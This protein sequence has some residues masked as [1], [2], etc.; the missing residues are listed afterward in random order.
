MKCLNDD[1][2]IKLITHDSRT[3]IDGKNISGDKISYHK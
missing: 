1:K 2:K 3:L